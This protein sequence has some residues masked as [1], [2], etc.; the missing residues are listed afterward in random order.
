MEILVVECPEFPNEEVQYAVHVEGDDGGVDIPNMPFLDEVVEG[1]EVGDDTW[2]R[3]KTEPH[4][5]AEVRFLWVH[6]C[7]GKA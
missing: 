4:E 3:R 6:R 2:N 1:D 7:L 5:E